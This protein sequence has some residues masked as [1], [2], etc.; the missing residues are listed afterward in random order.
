VFEPCARSE[1]T[2]R[3]IIICV[4]GELMFDT[5]FVQQP[6]VSKLCMYPYLLRMSTLDKPGNR[7]FFCT[8]WTSAGISTVTHYLQNVTFHAVRE[9]LYVVATVDIGTGQELSHHYQNWLPLFVFVSSLHLMHARHSTPSQST[10]GSWRWEC[11]WVMRRHGSTGTLGPGVERK[12][13]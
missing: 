2:D 1:L 6:D 8:P 9:E 3:Q 10:T 11:R 13:R 4:Q 12:K 7:Y 5:C